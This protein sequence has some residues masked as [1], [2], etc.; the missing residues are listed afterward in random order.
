MLEITLRVIL[1]IP[2]YLNKFIIITNYIKHYETHRQDA[3]R[4][5]Y[6][7]DLVIHGNSTIPHVNVVLNVFSSNNVLSQILLAQPME[8]Q[9]R[10]RAT[11]AYLFLL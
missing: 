9:L 6:D 2:F 11:K 3:P 5:L 1:F 4:H 8:Q 7:D 10:K